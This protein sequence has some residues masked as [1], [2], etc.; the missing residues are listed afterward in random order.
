MATTVLSGDKLERREWRKTMKTSE[1]MQDTCTS[2]MPTRLVAAIALAGC[3]VL[4][5]VPVLEEVV[6]TAQKLTEAKNK[7]AAAAQAST[8]AEKAAQDWRRNPELGVGLTL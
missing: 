3:S 4:H 8:A 7:V 2:G 6:V 1:A 5:A